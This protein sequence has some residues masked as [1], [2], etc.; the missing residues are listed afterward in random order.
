MDIKILFTILISTI[1]INNYVFSRILGLCPYLGVSKKLDSAIGMGLAVIFVMTMASF[2]TFIMY[3]YVLVPYHIEYLSIIAFIIVIA[4][5]VQFVEMVIEKVSTP[6]YQAL[7]IFLP[8]ITTNC[9]VL[10]V[11][12]LNIDS[13]FASQDFGLLYSV[14]QGFGGGAGFTIALILMAGIRER[15]EIAMIP[16]NLKGL[17]I[18]FITAGLMAISFLGFSGMKIF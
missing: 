7:G 9:A 16:E 2:F 5:L 1:F 15:L 4:S 14:V 6:L 3:K 11:A 12:V 8:L 13:G 18:T 10:G 17:P